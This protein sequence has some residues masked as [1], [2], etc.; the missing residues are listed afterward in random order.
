MKTSFLDSL[1]LFSF[2]ARGEVAVLQRDRQ[3]VALQAVVEA[4]TATSMAGRSLL[5]DLQQQRIAVAVQVGDEQSLDMAAALA[6]A[7]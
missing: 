6:L 1:D 2:H 7:P 3:A 5:L 4:G